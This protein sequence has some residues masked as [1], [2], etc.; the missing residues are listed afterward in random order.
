MKSFKVVKVL[1]LTLLFCVVEVGA[2]YAG[3]FI[4]DNDTNKTI[5]R[6]Y[7]RRS[8][9][10]SWG[11]PQNSRSIPRGKTFELRNIPISSS[12]R[13]WDIRVVFSGGGSY[14]WSDKNLYSKNRMTIYLKGS[15]VK[16]DWD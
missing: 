13:Y 3:T 15:S 12:H 4:I 5:T 8:D 2:A 11:N 1:V 7:V 6:I 10:S 14:T 9:K 16:A